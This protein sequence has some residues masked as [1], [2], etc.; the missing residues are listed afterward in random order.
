MNGIDVVP[1]LEKLGALAQAAAPAIGVLLFMVGMCF[2]A[3]SGYIMWM[4]REGR[5][6]NDDVPMGAVLGN[7]FVGAALIQL[8]KTV[9]NTREA[10]GGAGSDVRSAM[11]YMASGAG[12]AAAVY[13]IA[14]GTAFAWL[15]LIGICAIVRGLLMW[16]ELAAGGNRG[17]GDNLTW[18]GLWHIVG[19]GICVNI[20]I[21]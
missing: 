19:G 8:N 10:L 3:R 17:G 5:G 14:M 21:G 2:V 12:D 4:G 18:A 20:G 6:V 1:L 16:R 15:A 11:Q 13:K 9:S 7:L